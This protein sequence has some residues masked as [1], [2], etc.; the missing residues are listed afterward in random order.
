[1]LFGVIGFALNFA[2]QSEL[3]NLIENEDYAVVKGCIEEY[4][5]NVPKRGTKVESFKIENIYFEFSNYD[6]D[7]YFNSEDHVDNYLANGQ[8]VTISYVQIGVANKI[9]KISS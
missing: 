7:L 6:S 1:M 2:K 4:K 9:V 3:Q 8:C 5:I